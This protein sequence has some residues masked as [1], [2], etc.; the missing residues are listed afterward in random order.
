MDYSTSLGEEGTVTRVNLDDGAGNDNVNSIANINSEYAK[1]MDTL[2][3]YGASHSSHVMG[4]SLNSSHGKYGDVFTMETQPSRV[5]E[6]PSLNSVYQITTMARNVSCECLSFIPI[7][8]DKINIA[9]FFG[10]PFKT[11]ADFDN[12]T[13]DIEMGK[14]EEFL[15]Q[16]TEE[17]RDEVM[18]AIFDYWMPFQGMSSKVSPNDPIIKSLD[19]IT[20]PTSYAGAA[21]ENA[22]DQPKV[23]LNF[24]PLVADHV[25]NGLNISIPRKVVENVS[26][27]FEHTLYGYFI[28]KRMAYPVFKS[29]AGLEDVLEGGPWL[30]RKYLIILKKWS[31]DTRLL[32]EELT[33]IPIWVK[34]HDVPLQVFE[35]DGIS[36]IATFIGKPVMLDSYTSS[37]CKC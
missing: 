36:L 29:R 8:S 13:R 35:E 17:R 19:I 22:K 26:T 23:N 5:L 7:A 31:T 33:R 11:M 1:K 34:L 37:M 14:Y 27:R 24:R 3:V 10:V 2:F 16:L 12:L 21:G 32:K 18:E 28:G 9:E 20:K 6:Y 4:S 15:S 30:I 25:F